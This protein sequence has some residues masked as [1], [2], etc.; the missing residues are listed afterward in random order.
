[1][2]DV[3]RFLTSLDLREFAYAGLTIPTFPTRIAAALRNVERLDIRGMC[4]LVG[5]RLTKYFPR[6]RS[7]VL[8]REQAK[9]CGAI[10]STAGVEVQVQGECV[11]CKRFALNERLPRAFQTGKS[12][13]SRSMARATTNKD[14]MK[15]LVSPFPL[16]SGRGGKKVE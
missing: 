3:Q 4:G 1:M 7:I 10:F 11:N 9:A 16:D 8:S 14:L 2:A 12:Q 5:R 6:L 13:H 15:V